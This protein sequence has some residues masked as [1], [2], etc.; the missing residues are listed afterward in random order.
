MALL[1][2]LFEGSTTSSRVL[3][4]HGE[5]ALSPLT[6]E[7]QKKPRCCNFLIGRFQVSNNKTNVLKR[8]Q[9]S[10]SN[11]PEIREELES[12]T[13]LYIVRESPDLENVDG[14]SM[15]LESTSKS[16]GTIDNDIVLGLPAHE[17]PIAVSS[18]LVMPSFASGLSQFSD[19]ESVVHC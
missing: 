3:V 6:P 1:E 8:F 10:K 4:V 13:L 18:Q 7:E 12:N 19:S 2:A 15:A 9:L 14:D 16:E 17:T 11:I 5:Q